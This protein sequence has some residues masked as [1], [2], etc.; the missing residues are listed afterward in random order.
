[1]LVQADKG[2]CTHN[3]SKADGPYPERAQKSGRGTV[4]IMPHGKDRRVHRYWQNREGTARIH[5]GI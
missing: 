5:S 2:G 4:I 3:R 1:M